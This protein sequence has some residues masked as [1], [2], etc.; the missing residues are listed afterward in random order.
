MED[1]AL[2]IPRAFIEQHN[3][4][5]SCGVRDLKPFREGA[6]RELRI[7]RRSASTSTDVPTAPTATS[8]PDEEVASQTANSNRLGPLPVIE[9]TVEGP[10]SRASLL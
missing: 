4:G 3:R 5:G 8:V 2:I 7:V 6:S 1:I 9:T 10:R